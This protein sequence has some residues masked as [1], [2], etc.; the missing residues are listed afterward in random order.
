MESTIMAGENTWY[1][2]FPSTEH[3]VD[4][5]SSHWA[6]IRSVESSNPGADQSDWGSFR[7]FPQSLRKMLRWNYERCPQSKFPTRPT[8]SKLNHLLREATVCT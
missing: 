5:N 3:S 6:R 1:Y 8:A 7:G 2:R 4:R